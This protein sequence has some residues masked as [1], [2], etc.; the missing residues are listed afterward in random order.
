MAYFS[1]LNFR[2]YPQNIW[3]YIWY[4][5]VPPYFRILQIS[6]WVNPSMLQRVDSLRQSLLH[7]SIET[8][9]FLSSLSHHPVVI[10][11]HSY[12]LS[13]V[14]PLFSI[15]VPKII[16]VDSEDSH[17]GRFF[18]HGIIVP[19]VSRHYPTIINYCIIYVYRYSIFQYH[20]QARSFL[21]VFYHCP[22]HYPTKIHR[23][24]TFQQCFLSYPSFLIIPI[25]DIIK[26]TRA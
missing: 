14:I 10:L 17:F 16:T 1:G 25:T 18:F 6:H 4:V 22:H 12:V 13:C 20:Y 5:Y 11:Y 15:F 3:P 19:Q 21:L 26:S 23:F 7:Q 9:D 8:R 2:E 24:P